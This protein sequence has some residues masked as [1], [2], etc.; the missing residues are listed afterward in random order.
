MPP[1]ERSSLFAA[2][3]RRFL[4]DH[5]PSTSHRPL[6][7]YTR[8]TDYSGSRNLSCYYCRVRFSFSDLGRKLAGQINYF[9]PGWPIV[10]ARQPCLFKKTNKSRVNL[11][12]EQINTH[13]HTRA[14]VC[15][16]HT[17][18]EILGH[19]CTASRVYNFFYS[20]PP[21]SLL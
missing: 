2:Q 3:N 8:S 20:N 19:R 17:N 6:R 12:N 18:T 4:A 5:F 13:T 7:R 9:A 10:Y 16:L 1:W 15:T 14:Y 21:P 11:S